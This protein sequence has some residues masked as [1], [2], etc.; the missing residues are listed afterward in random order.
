MFLPALRAFS[1]SHPPVSKT[2]RTLASSSLREALSSCGVGGGAGGLAS[3]VAGAMAATRAGAGESRR[4]TRGC[5]TS[6]LGGA[7]LSVKNAQSAAA[8]KTVSAAR[9][10]FFVNGFLLSLSG[11]GASSAAFLA[12]RPRLAGAGAGASSATAVAFSRANA[13]GLV[14]AT[15]AA[16]SGSAPLKN[17]AVEARAV[18]R[19]RAN[20]GEGVA[21]CATAGTATATTT[22]AAMIVLAARGMILRL[23]GGASFGELGC[24][25]PGSENRHSSSSMK[26]WS[27]CV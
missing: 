1:T 19:T 24:D 16:A 27:P 25:S 15:V 3:G 12:K 26:L 20:V 22:A 18:S 10:V 5:L 21:L 17:R 4:R 2:T 14:S 7:F 23:L 11:S 6:S 13:G 9:R 8:W